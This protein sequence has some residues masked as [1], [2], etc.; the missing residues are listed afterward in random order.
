MA[1]KLMNRIDNCNLWSDQ[2]E[3][4]PTSTGNGKS[5]RTEFE[6]DEHRTT[7]E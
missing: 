6:P 7:T 4:Q 5:T 1:N 3:T 2:A